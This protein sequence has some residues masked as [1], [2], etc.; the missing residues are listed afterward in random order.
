MDT[1]IWKVDKNVDNL[2]TYPQIIEAARW[3]QKNALVAFPTE[4]VYG[5]GANAKSDEA[6][7]KI[8]EA[9]GRPS[10]NPLIIHISDQEEVAQY[11]EEIPEVASKLMDRFWPGPLTIILRKRKGILSDRA[12]T[13]LPT[14]ALRM[15]DHPI[16]LAVIR[17]SGLPIAAPSANLSGKP[18]PTKF[19][20]VYNDMNGKIAG[21]I[22]GGDT[23]VG[24]ESTVIDC[25]NPTPVILRPGGITK[26]EIEGVIGEVLMDPALQS[27]DE[28]PKSP[29]MKYTHYAPKAPVL[30]VDG[31]DLFIQQ[32]IDRYIAEGKKVGVLTTEEKKNRWKADIVLGCGKRCDLSTVANRLYDS[33]RAFDETNVEIIL[34][35][36]FPNRGIGRAIMNRLMKAAGHRILKQ[37]RSI[38]GRNIVNWKETDNR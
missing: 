9:K 13:S 8:F 14:V 15:P 21:I 1:K 16:A 4:T 35:E 3:L 27:N 31:S 38:D 7:K 36:T 37:S 33:L 11:V 30:L 32:T 5:L 12:T 6:V 24:L 10:D 22:D 17:A 20:H 34:S 26:E 2:L 23:G 25:T 18:S 28:K 19:T 29:G